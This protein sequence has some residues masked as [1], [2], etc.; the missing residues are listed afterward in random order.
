MPDLHA[1]VQRMIEGGESEDDIANVIRHFSAA[2]SRPVSAEDFAPPQ[3]DGSALGRFVSNAAEMLN[4]ITM[5]TGTAH[6]L[7]HPVDTA[8]ALIGAQVGEAQKAADAAREGRLSETLGHGAAALL[9]LV[10]PLAAHA[11]EQI[12]SGDIAGGLGTT[13]GLLAPAALGAFAHAAPEAGLTVKPILPVADADAL[14]FAERNAIPVD[15]ATATSN[16]FVKAAQHLSD[17]SLAGSVVANRAGA[18]QAERLA[19]IGEQLAAK[20]HPTPMS[21]AAAGDLARGA[22]GEV[23]GTQNRLAGDAYD[24]LRALEAAS[25]TDFAGEVPAQLPP[26]RVGHFTLPKPKATLSDDQLDAFLAKHGGTNTA[27]Q[28]WRAAPINTPLPAKPLVPM[29]VD[30]G[31]VQEAIKPL[32]DQLAAKKA[33]VGS[34]MGHEAT[35]AAKIDALLNGPQH[36]PLSVADSALSD[37]KAIT[38]TPKGGLRTPGQAKAAAVVDQLHQAVGRTAQAAGPEATAALEA[39]R[40]A[41]KAKYAAADVLKFLSGPNNTKSGATAF[42]GLTQTGDTAA[43]RL[44]DV[45]TQAPQTK[46][47]IARA[48]L[49]GLIAHPTAGA[50]KTW[51]DW[52]KL[53]ARTKALLFTPEHTKD[54]NDF[55]KLRKLIAENPNPSGTAHTAL[56]L[57]QGGL[58]LAEPVSGASVQLGSGTLSALL[59]SPRA[60]KL[61][62]KGFTIPLADKAASAAWLAAL[63]KAVGDATNPTGFQTATGPAR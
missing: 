35:A 55:F 57:A 37:L 16:K 38:R 27:P 17:R 7:A 11:G 22:V 34:L 36:V 8:K 40:T 28:D 46:P 51:A 60:V 14:A 47:V 6:A 20:A 30:I 41:T 31:P 12:G 58:L 42:R 25:Q 54:L 45:L 39:G 62:T 61:L 59:H 33:V 2:P 21:A 5:I 13:A 19:T 56:S 3:P 9:P 15:A 43:N 29:V 4:P 44:R 48:V 52:N 63:S 32:A 1:L 53:G 23:V 18:A 10:G 50:A 49:D 26:D 24:T